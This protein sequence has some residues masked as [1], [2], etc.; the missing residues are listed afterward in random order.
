MRTSFAHLAYRPTALPT[1][2]RFIFK[3]FED[4]EASRGANPP[5]NPANPPG[6]QP[7]LAA[8]LERLLARN[9]GSFD[10]T[11][12]QL[13]NE[14]HGYRQRIRE[15]EGRVP[16]GSVVLA[17]DDLARWQAYQALGAP[18]DVQTAIAERDTFRTTLTT[19]ERAD[20][21][22]AAAE[23]TGFK[24]SVLGDRIG[25]L[26]V[27]VREVEEGG[28][29]VKRAFIKLENNTEQLLTE[30]A[31]REWADYLPALKEVKQS[32]TRFI[33]QN[34]GSGNEPPASIVDEF[35]E[36]RRKAA[37]ARSNPLQKKR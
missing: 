26:T 5:A 33:P 13:L 2:G 34:P 20:L 29:K 11:G 32:G 19:R 35:I 31:A 1:S 10:A 7:D 21:V 30:Y 8:A 22:S 27:E 4:P 16:E 28:K 15:L 37:E 14:N 12:V 24:A 6:N 18:T 3:R 17:G 25:D 23:A 9:G 36:R